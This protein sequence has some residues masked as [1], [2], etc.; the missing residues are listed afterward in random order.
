MGLLDSLGVALGESDAPALELLAGALEEYHRLQA[1]MAS[2]DEKGLIRGPTYATVTES[3]SVMYRKRP[4][5]ELA[6]DA[7]KRAAAM[8][9]KFG[10]TAVDRTRVPAKPKG[11]AADPGATKRERFF[12]KTPAR[13]V[14]L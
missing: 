13:V 11:G 5:A 9:A 14:G 8:L 1:W 6:S 4:E 2:E 10:L 7:W 3:G 12:G